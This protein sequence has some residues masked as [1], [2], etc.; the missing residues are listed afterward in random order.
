MC[1]FVFIHF[2]IFMISIHYYATLMSSKNCGTS[3]SVAA[4]C[5]ILFW[6]KCYQTFVDFEWNFYFIKNFLNW[7]F[8]YQRISTLKKHN[9]K[10]DKSIKF[11]IQMFSLHHP[12]TRMLRN[13]KG[14]NLVKTFQGCQNIQKK[15]KICMINENHES[16]RTAREGECW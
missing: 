3:M 2:Y 15:P 5:F 9:I 14:K 1:L 8:L 12:K 11:K 4:L 13:Q 7:K 6:R 10:P 16:V